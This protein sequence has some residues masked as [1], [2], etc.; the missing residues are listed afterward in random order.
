MV[1]DDITIK[2]RK[3]LSHDNY[4]KL[5]EFLK[6]DEAKYYNKDLLRIVKAEVDGNPPIYRGVIIGLCRDL[7]LTDEKKAREVAKKV[8]RN[9][10]DVLFELEVF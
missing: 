5:V 3:Y 7:R 9:L 2:L 1:D 4:Q 6:S 10:V 8:L